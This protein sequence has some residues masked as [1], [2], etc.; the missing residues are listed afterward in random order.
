MDPPV[1]YIFRVMYSYLNY[2]W[3]KRLN[4]IV[5]HYGHHDSAFEI[6]IKTSNEIWNNSF[7]FA[8]V[9]NPWDWHVSL[10]HYMKQTTTHF[11]H[12]IIKHMSFEDYCYWRFNNDPIIQTD[13]LIDEENKYLLDYIGKVEDIF[14]EINYISKKIGVDLNLSWENKSI[15]DRNYR[16]YYNERL[17]KIIGDLSEPDII[18]F[19][20][21]F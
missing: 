17:K 13:F 5:K 12:H 9:R 1:D 2:K 3:K 15:R 21:E 6:K 10:F 18:N 8:F 4:R 16:N 14:Y 19:K 7:K 20:Y 11:Q